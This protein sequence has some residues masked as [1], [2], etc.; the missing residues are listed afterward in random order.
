MT[1]TV[2][3]SFDYTLFPN[4]EQT[5]DIIPRVQQ[6]SNQQVSLSIDDTVQN[7]TVTP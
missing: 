7:L 1:L 5:C 6:Y 2:K 3:C 4:D